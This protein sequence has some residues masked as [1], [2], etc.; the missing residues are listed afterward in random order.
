MSDLSWWAV[1][2]GSWGLWK[3]DH[4]YVCPKCMTPFRVMGPLVQIPPVEAVD[5]D[6]WVKALEWRMTKETA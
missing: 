6:R 3:E 2:P 4:T 1:R 5:V